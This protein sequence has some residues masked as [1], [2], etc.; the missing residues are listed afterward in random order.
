[1]VLAIAATLLMAMFGHLLAMVRDLLL[2]AMIAGFLLWALCWPLN[3]K[4]KG[5]GTFKA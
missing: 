5:K 2:V 4:G 3:G 1:M